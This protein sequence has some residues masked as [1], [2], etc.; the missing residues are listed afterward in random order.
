MWD[1]LIFHLEDHAPDWV[2]EEAG[3]TSSGR[4]SR[5]FALACVR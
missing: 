5:K 2:I 1:A 4:G 3:A